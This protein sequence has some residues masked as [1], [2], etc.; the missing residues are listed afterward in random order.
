[1]NTWIAFLRG[2]GGGIRPLPMKELQAALAKGGLCD[3]RTYIQTGNLVFK[4]AH[5]SAAPLGKRIGE[6][7]SAEFG[8][9]PQVMVL[10]RKDLERAVARN[11]FPRAEANRLHLFFMEQRPAAPD[12]DAMN[13][14]KAAGEAFVL[15]DKVY[16]L[17]TPEGFGTSKL[18]QRVERLLGV[19]AT[20]RNARTVYNVLEI[21]K[22]L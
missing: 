13:Q 8:F 17:H 2:I 20:A 4:S 14:V 18:A 15:E 12:I 16:Y 7:L 9:E 11:P 6:C 22:G 5:R 10:S 21:A 19:P 1:M 3:V